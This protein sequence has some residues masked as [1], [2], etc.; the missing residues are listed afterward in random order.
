MRTSAST[1]NDILDRDV[2]RLREAGHDVD[3]LQE[4][5]LVGIVICGYELPSGIYNRETTDI[6]LQT[7]LQYPA[8]AMD[9]LWVD[10][11]LLLASGAIPAGGESREHH[12]GRNWRRLSWHRNVPWVAGRDDLV[13]H[14]EFA[15]ARLARPQ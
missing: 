14:F 8:S 7:D 9:M 13:G 6:L 5:M 12:F 11:D 4:G 15:V 3:L 2:G 1:G 10:D